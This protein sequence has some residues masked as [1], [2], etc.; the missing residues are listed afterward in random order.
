[1]MSDDDHI[2][3]VLNIFLVIDNSNRKIEKNTSSL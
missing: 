2:K 1:M 3:M